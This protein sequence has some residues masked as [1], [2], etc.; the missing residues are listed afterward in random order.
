MGKL[1]F[2]LKSKIVFQHI[3]Y[4]RMKKPKLGK[5]CYPEQNIRI[6]FFNLRT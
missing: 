1:N 4:P 6:Y 2:V 5:Y 3:E